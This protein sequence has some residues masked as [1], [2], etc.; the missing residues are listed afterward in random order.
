M[1]IKVQEF[2]HK[3]GVNDAEYIKLL[4]HHLEMANQ[5]T[6]KA[7]AKI[8]KLSSERTYSLECAFREGMIAGYGIDHENITEEENA[9]VEE[10]LKRHGIKG[11]MERD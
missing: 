6:S 9:A 1:S 10:F 4:E 8:R 7:L 2:H 11:G 5:T 3:P